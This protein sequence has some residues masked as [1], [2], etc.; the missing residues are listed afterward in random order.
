MNRAQWEAWKTRHRRWWD[1]LTTPVLVIAIVVINA[2]IWVRR[3][4]RL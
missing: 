3:L 1:F 4:R 2:L